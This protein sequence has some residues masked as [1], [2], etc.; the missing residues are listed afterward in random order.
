MQATTRSRSRS[1]RS[2]QSSTA[3]LRDLRNRQAPRRERRH[4]SPN[5]RLRLSDP[6]SA[7]RRD[8]K[9]RA[10]LIPMQV[11]QSGTGA[12]ATR[13]IA[14]SGS[15]GDCAR[16]D[17]WVVDLA[18]TGERVNVEMK[19]VLGALVFASNVPDE[20]PCSVGGHSW[21]NH[22]TSGPARRSRARSPRQYLSDSLNVGF[23]VLQLRCRP[24]SRI[25]PTRASSGR[26]RPR[27]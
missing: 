4:R 1:G 11:T 24:A 2:S 23:T 14:C 7:R 21:F 22:L 26:A 12:T 6:G 3:S 8:P 19:L 10:D 5:R 18:E 9:T 20:V 25:R 27:A 15:A 16:T 17:G 13:T